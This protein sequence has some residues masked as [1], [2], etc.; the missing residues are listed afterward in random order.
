[1]DVK[2]EGG[3]KNLKKMGNVINGYRC[4]YIISVIHETIQFQS[5]KSRY[6]L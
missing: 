2:G 3:V 6:V 4:R 1:M 5:W